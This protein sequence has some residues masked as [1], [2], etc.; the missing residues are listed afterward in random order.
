MFF[1]KKKPLPPLEGKL[2]HIAFI[3]DG[4]GRWAKKR[5]LP[6]E[7]G[8]V[9][10][11]K[12]FRNLVE[13]CSTRGLKTVTFYA[14]STENWKRPEPEVQAILKLLDTYLDDA[15]ANLAKNAVRVRFLGDLSVL[16]ANLSEKMQN[17]ERISQKNELLLQIAFNYGGRAEIVHAVNTAL[18]QGKTTLTEADIEANLYTDD[19]YPP[20]LIVRTAGEKRLSNF[21]M[22]QSA[23]SEFYF[24]D[25]LWPDF[26]P[27]QLEQAIEDYLTRTRRF[28]GL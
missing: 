12:T 25:C 3:M 17:L 13:Y 4:N 6:R 11:A 24:T 27:A 28:G 23:Y 2:S 19:T 16:P 9:V 14:F 8:H 18:A 7:S 21:L 5:G 20:D 10:G 22:W 26:G 1:R 15:I